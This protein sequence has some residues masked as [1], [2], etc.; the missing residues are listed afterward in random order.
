MGSAKRSDTDAPQRSRRLP[1]WLKVK[2]RKGHLSQ[3]TQEML[4]A[5]HLHTVCQSAQCPNVGECFSSGTATLLLMGPHCTRNCG[6]CAVSS[7]AP[8]P[9][10]PDEPHR[11]AQAVAAM[12][13]S[14]VVVTSVT[15][16]DLPDGGAAHFAQTIRAIRSCSPHA[17]IEVLVPD[18]A[19]DEGCVAA[20]LEAGPAVLNHNVETVARLQPEVRPMAGYARSLGVLRA[21]RRIA[22]DVPTKSGLMVGLGESDQEIHDTLRD[23][24][25]A[26]VAIVTIGQYLRPSPRHLPVRRYVPPQRFGE[27]QE[28]GQ[29]LGLKHVVAGPFVRSSYRAETAAED[30]GV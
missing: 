26:G 22:P 17:R 4:A 18:F 9:L 24:A 14:Y 1:E 2:L 19:G 29:A 16:D 21:A 11:V 27:Y 10:D 23:L 28:V 12:E 30:A 20:V 13:L 6:F 7:A 25:D 15:R 8:S 5:A 3:Q